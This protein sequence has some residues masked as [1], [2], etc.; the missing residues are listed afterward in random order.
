MVPKRRRTEEEGTADVA[1]S[2]EYNAYRDRVFLIENTS[3]E[4][5]DALIELIDR[6][7]YER[8]PRNKFS[9]YSPSL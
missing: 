3:D 1:D 5:L 9:L 2:Y 4:A 7:D 8:L 6:F